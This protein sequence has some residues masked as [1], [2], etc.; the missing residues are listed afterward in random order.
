[1]A[2]NSQNVAETVADVVSRR[3]VLEPVLRAF[4]PLLAAGE[5]LVAQ[6]AE[7]VREA[8]LRLPQLQW[9]RARQGVSLLAGVPLTGIAGPMR[10]AART[11]LPL[12]TSIEAVAPHVESLKAFFLRPVEPGAEDARTALAE[13]VVGGRSVEAIAREGGVEPDVLTFVT[14]FVLSPVLHA[15]VASAMPVSGDAM[16]DE[17]NAWQRGYCPVCGAFPTIGWL[18]RPVVDDKNAYL[19]GGGGKK[20]LHC[21]VCGAGWKFLR[22]ACPSCGKDASGT[23]EMLRESEAA[24]GERLDWCTKCKTYCPTV[25]LRE[26]EAVPNMDVQALGMM[27]LDM[28]AARK[29]LRPLRPSFWNMY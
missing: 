20:H 22:G 27:H 15:V 14:G 3:P 16:W 21:S 4:E 12:M 13:A 29:Q 25:D 26:R 6:L 1:M 23:M 19:A 5:T 17:G 2:T 10:E 7:P 11:L 18:D 9:D 8:G 28:V 24:G